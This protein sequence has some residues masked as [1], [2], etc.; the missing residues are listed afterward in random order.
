VSEISFG[1]FFFVKIKLKSSSS[2]ES[3][4]D[5]LPSVTLIC[6]FRNKSL[7]PMLS[8]YT[9]RNSSWSSTLVNYFFHT[10]LKFIHEKACGLFITRINSQRIKKSDF[11]LEFNFVMLH[12]FA[13]TTWV[14]EISW[15]PK[16]ATLI[17][18]I[19]KSINLN[20][21]QSK[22][23]QPYHAAPQNEQAP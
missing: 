13:R 9:R 19:P 21:C 3:Y 2:S 8:N 1:S 11:K 22:W 12:W 23:T 5:S 18:N 10:A 14:R 15:T 16:R 20:L 17:G 6:K 4:C 7:H